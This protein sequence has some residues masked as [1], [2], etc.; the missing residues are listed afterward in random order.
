MESKANKSMRLIFIIIISIS[1]LKCSEKNINN[2]NA[3]SQIKNKYAKGFEIYE[4]D[5]G[6]W[7]KT[8]NPQTGKLTGELHLSNKKST[9]KLGKVIPFSATHIGFLDLLDRLN[10]VKGV[11]Y[12]EGIFNT[13]I[14]TQY[15]DGK[16]KNIGSDIEPNKELI[17]SINPDLVFTFPNK[18]NYQWMD[19]L[20]IPHIAITEFMEE[21]PLAQAEWIR[22]FGYLYGIPQKAD[23]IFHFIDSSYQSLVQKQPNGIRVLAGELFNDNWTLPGGKSFTANLIKDAGGTYVSFNDSSYGSHKIDYEIIVKEQTKIDIWTML[24]FDY[25]DISTDYILNKNPKYQFLTLLDSN[26]MVVC[27]SAKTPYF[28]SGVIQPHK[29]LLDLIRAFQN[30]SK[31]NKYFKSIH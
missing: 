27:N 10:S 20:N 3:K 9:N 4:G 19:D 17:A 11:T 2:T 24:T 7:I 21:H 16:I 22:F 1:F 26:K 14:K 8:L 18:A 30:D 15:R 6:L 31:Q 12:P 5:N 13:T 23:S 28:E 29:L 25:Q